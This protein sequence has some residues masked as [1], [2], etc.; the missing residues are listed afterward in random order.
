MRSVYERRVAEQTEIGRTILQGA[1]ECCSGQFGRAWKGMFP[2]KAAE[3]LAVR[4][5]MSVRAAA[6]QLSGEHEPSARAIA[7][8]VVEATKKR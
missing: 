2:I 6:Y 8:L 1:A 4:A 3:E 7:A 5:G